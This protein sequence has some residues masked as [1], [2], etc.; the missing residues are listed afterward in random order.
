METK[1]TFVRDAAKKA[2]IA[3]I[4]DGKFVHED[5]SSL[6]LLPSLEKVKWISLVATILMKEKIGNITN[7]LVDDGTGQI[8]LRFFEIMPLIETIDAGSTLL[9]I[10]K[11]RMYNQER[12]LSPEIV[13]KVPL[14]W[15]KVRRG[16]L[17]DHIPEPTTEQV[18]PGESE[19]QPTEEPALPAQKVMQLIKDLDSGEGARIEELLER[20]PLKQT[21]Q[22]LEKLIEAGDIFQNLPGRVKVL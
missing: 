17:K 18:E 20:S 16:E 9:I 12:Y 19:V 21:E 2:T 8:V 4:L 3:Q 6:F 13:K 10:G 1:T 5:E 22:L 14:L 11:P 7:I 15:L